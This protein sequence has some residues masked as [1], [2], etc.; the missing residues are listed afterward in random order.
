MTP[1]IFIF[2]NHECRI[3]IL[4]DIHCYLRAHI[5]WEYYFNLSQCVKYKWHNRKWNRKWYLLFG[6]LC[7]SWKCTLCKQYVIHKR[8]L[9]SSLWVCKMLTSAW[10]GN[11]YGQVGYG[12]SNCWIQ[13]YLDLKETVFYYQNCSDLLWEKN[14]VVKNFCKFFEFTI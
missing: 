2:Y 1:R 4:C 5:F 14:V 10:V 8:H 6:C 13:N 3:S 11:I 12:V 7:A 9:P